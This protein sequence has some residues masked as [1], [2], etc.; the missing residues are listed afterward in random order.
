MLDF[1][2]SRSEAIPRIPAQ[3]L[4]SAGTLTS[5]AWLLLTDSIHPFFVYL[6]QLY[7]TF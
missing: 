1:A 5:F 6:L 4:V 3:F 2:R 7:L